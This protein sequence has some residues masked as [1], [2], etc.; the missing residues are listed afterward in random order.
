ME[1]ARQTGT[2]PQSSGI[3][4]T[5]LDFVEKSPHIRGIRDVFRQTPRILLM[6]AGDGDHL[7]TAENRSMRAVFEYLSAMPKSDSAE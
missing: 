5:W 2:F 7:G 6:G 3:N 4:C 1:N